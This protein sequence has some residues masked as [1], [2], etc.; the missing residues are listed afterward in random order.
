VAGRTTGRPVRPADRDAREFQAAHDE[1]FAD[2]W[3]YV[4][5]D[6]ESWSKFHLES[7]RFD[8]SLWCVVRAGNEIAAGT[9]CMAESYGGGWVQ[10]LFTVL[11]WT[12][13]EKKLAPAP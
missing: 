12:V 2:H 13:Y 1:A 5:R 4:P 3:D 6:F 11:G 9:I 7:E 8:P 10:A